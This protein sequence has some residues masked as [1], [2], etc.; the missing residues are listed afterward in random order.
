MGT[1]LATYLNDHLAGAT[2]AV[3]LVERT[4]REQSGRPL[5]AFL[6]KLA[7][8]I[9]A[10]KQALEDVMAAAGVEKDQPKL[11]LA[12]LMEKVGRLRID[13]R[14]LGRA[15][16]SPLLELESLVLGITGKA[17]LWRALATLPDPPTGG[18][19]L[20]QLEERAERQRAEVEEHRLAIAGSALRK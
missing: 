14:V 2:A 11:V 7:G 13:D 10:D 12:S 20:E 8:E 4:A 16:P 15:T 6:S 1:A 9:R 3:D 5:G 18:H 19:S 17:L